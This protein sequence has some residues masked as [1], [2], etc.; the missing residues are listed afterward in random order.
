MFG[1]DERL[2]AAGV[3]VALALLS[4]DGRTLRAADCNNNGVDDRQDIA[5]G[6]SPDCNGNG[7]PDECDLAAVNF[8]FAVTGTVAVGERPRGST[9]AD[10][11]GDGDLDLAVVN[12]YSDNVSVLLN[13]GD[14]TFAPAVNY[15][16][17]RYPTSITSGD[18]DG[19]GDVDLAV[20]SSKSGFGVK[21]WV[22]KNHGD[23][24]FGSVTPF[25]LGI[26][27]DSVSLGDFDGDGDLDLAVTISRSND[28][29]VLWNHGTFFTVGPQFAVG[30][31]LDAAIPA[32][33][34]G[35]GDVDLIVTDG[36]VYDYPCQCLVVD[37]S[38]SVLL[39]EGNGTFV[40]AGRFPF[41]DRRP[42]VAAGD[43]DGDGDLDL[44]VAD[45]GADV[46]TILLND[47]AAFFTLGS[48]ISV[49]REIP[50]PG[51]GDL[52]VSVGD[53]DG[54]GD[55]D[56][57]VANSGSR[58]VAVL[59]NDGNANFVPALRHFETEGFG[60]FLEILDLDGDGALDLAVVNSGGS[61]AIL[62]NQ[63]VV[64]SQDCNGNGVP[65]EC[66]IV[67]G[68]CFVCR[69]GGV[70]DECEI[71]DGTREDLDGN[72]VP[73]D[74]EPDCNGN[75]WDDAIDL[76]RGHRDCNGNAVPD[77]CDL[78]DGVLHDADTN[79][80][81]DECE[82][83]ASF[84]RF[85]YRLEPSF[86]FCPRLDAVYS[87]DIE[88]NDDGDYVLNM[89]IAELGVEGQD[90]CLFPGA[91]ASYPCVLETRLSPRVLSPD[92]VELVRAV[93]SEIKL[94]TEPLSSGCGAIDRCMVQ[95]FTW[96]FLEV[97]D[98][99]CAVPRLRRDQV[100]LV[101]NLL[102]R[103]RTGP[104]DCNANG[105]DDIL[106]I[107][108]GTSDDAH[109]DGVPDECVPGD[110]DGDGDVDLAD[111]F[112]FVR[113]FS[114]ARVPVEVGCAEADLDDDG[115]VDLADLIAFQAAFTGTR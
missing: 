58:S 37:G 8:G 106:D 11:D 100:R 114:G 60:R 22:L 14:G 35:D 46:V 54:D 18:L 89:S 71:A 44:A 74:C 84:R 1:I 88:T 16:V 51:A 32:D 26:A 53:L 101:S 55:L 66:D 110:G 86:G 34:D 107:A 80:I 57:A 29:G 111:Y 95:R 82:D 38:V 10:L 28:V 108:T 20:G 17:G 93:F 52:E 5:E 65:D 50:R 27:Q 85:R 78:V 12:S 99:P 40:A 47:G 36:G 92:E 7:N 2:A 91:R 73:D 102:E 42:S 64:V 33:L 76:V 4:A 61:V 72:G 77:E 62:R 97:S 56:V 70:P 115:D 79:G 87:A 98:H 19:D 39:N 113:C 31:A 105:V 24:S 30:E 9:M 6:T 15:E 63:P 94:E 41:A 112:S 96:H 49:R 109:G 45:S 67:A 59:L 81:P 23:G 83:F 69:P 21:F 13:R 68:T 43:F 104:R 48:S 75:G 3:V 90:D 25:R 103:L